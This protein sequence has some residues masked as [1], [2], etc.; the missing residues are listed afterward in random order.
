MPK[1]ECCEFV[2]ISH[3]N[4]SGAVFLDTVYVAAT[5]QPSTVPGRRIAF[6]SVRLSVCPS[7]RPYVRLS[8]RL[9]RSGILAKQL[10]IITLFQHLVDTF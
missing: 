4:R 8:V 3:I 7:V 2:K 6:L 5:A 9:S 10:N 1:S